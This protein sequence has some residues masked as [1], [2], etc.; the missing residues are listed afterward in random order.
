MFILF[1]ILYILYYKIYLLTD[2][3]LTLMNSIEKGVTET[4]YRYLHTESQLKSLMVLTREN[5]NVHEGD[6]DF[7]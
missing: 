2:H 3:K 1:I 5:N 7:N 4:K 6:N